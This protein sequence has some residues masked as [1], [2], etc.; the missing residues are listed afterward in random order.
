P[1]FVKIFSKKLGWH[2]VEEGTGDLLATFGPTDVFHYFYALLYSN[3]YRRNYA[4]FLRVDFPRLPV[5]SSA[6]LVGHLC[7]QGADLIAFHLLEDD[8]LAASWNFSK[9]KGK[10]PLQNLITK[11]AGKGD[12]EVAKGYPKYAAGK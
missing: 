3:A 5:A 6:K 1:E 10:S 7:N 12:D 2:F 9:P 11:F 4:E 8:Y